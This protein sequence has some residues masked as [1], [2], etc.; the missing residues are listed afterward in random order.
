MGKTDSYLSEVKRKKLFDEQYK[1]ATLEELTKASLYLQQ[2]Q[3]ISQSKAQKDI[4]IMLI[5]GIVIITLNVIG[6]LWLLF[7][8]DRYWTF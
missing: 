7:F 1:N 6:Y 5:I 2:E 8:V 3:A 4:R